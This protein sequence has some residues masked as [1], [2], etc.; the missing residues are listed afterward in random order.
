MRKSFVY[1]FLIV[2]SIALAIYFSSIILGNQ[3]IGI[4]VQLNK[5]HKWGIIDVHGWAKDIG[6]K[7][8][9][10][11][12]K[13]NDSSPSNHWT[14]IKYSSVERADSL[15]INNGQSFT[16]YPVTK[17]QSTSTILFH[18]VFPVA[19]MVLLIIF[20][21]L[22]IRRKDNQRPALILTCFLLSYGLSSL[23]SGASARADLIGK[24]I[25]V[26]A[27]L[28]L[29]IVLLHFLYAF[30]KTHD[31]HFCNFK[32]F[33]ILYGWNTM[34]F[35][36]QCLFFIIHLGSY[37][38]ILITIE[39]L[40]FLATFIIC[41]FYY[42]KGFIKYKTTDYKSIFQLI[43][44]GS[45]GSF[46]PMI[47]FHII[48]VIFTYQPIINGDVVGLFTFILPITLF[49]LISTE[50]LFDID[51]FISRLAYYAFISLGTTPLF[52]W[53]VSLFK[54][55]LSV[56]EMVELFMV[57]YFASIFILYIK[58]EADYLFRQKLFFEKYNYQS[59]LYQFVHYLANSLKKAEIEMHIL[60][61]IKSVLKVNSATIVEYDINEQLFSA[62]VHSNIISYID[63]VTKRKLPIGD[64]KHIGQTYVVILGGNTEKLYLLLLT[65]KRNHTKLNINEREWLKTISYLVN[66]S[67][68][69]LQLVEDLIFQ[70]EHLRNKRTAPPWALRLLFNIQEQ[71]RKKFATD[72]HDSTLQTQLI[73]Y[74]KLESFYDEHKLT[75]I[76]K[77]ELEEIKDGFMDVIYEIRQTCDEMMPPFLKEFGLKRALSEL[78]NKAQM[79]NLFLVDLDTSKL[80]DDLD[81]EYVLLFYRIIQELLNNAAKHSNA[82]RIQ[83]YLKNSEDTITLYYCDNGK[84]FTINEVTENHFGLSGIQ[85]RVK[86]VGGQIVLNTG[87]GQG[88]EVKVVIPVENHVREEVGKD[89]EGILG[90]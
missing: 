60:N 10:I 64:M 59:T 51:F 16:Y 67:F 87:I 28:Y 90:R 35:L 26:G 20:S 54:P 74:R 7:K 24:I 12:D 79:R 70:I 22:L 57:L 84:G 76:Q 8:G 32:L 33:P 73:W 43:T 14:V 36:M 19:F 15:V 17:D 31:I 42:I 66:L 62:A 88:V 44:L 25:V 75:S 81:N 82:D 39:L 48:P 56:S 72:L 89:D 68:E 41:L 55:Q 78:V 63:E 4:D 37:Y 40:T 69:S 21:I 9:D 52:L 23:A 18:F 85:E 34:I 3:Y 71:E 1:I 46:A 65:G 13:I 86:S 45:L 61:E 6:I 83:I 5:D 80:Q 53:I 11:V 77:K 58:E 30:F 38:N 50:E 47:I 2:A 27:L 49:Y 29:P